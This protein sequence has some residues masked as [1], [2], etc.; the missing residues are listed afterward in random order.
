MPSKIAI[1]LWILY[2]LGIVVASMMGKPVPREA[3]DASQEV[4]GV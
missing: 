2:E 3:K 4:T 1:P